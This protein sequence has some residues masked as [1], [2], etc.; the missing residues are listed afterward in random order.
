SD[1]IIMDAAYEY[2]GCA[3]LQ[4]TASALTEMIKGKSID[5]ISSITVEDI[6]NYLEGLP[7][8]KLD[9]AVLASSTLQKALELYKKKEPV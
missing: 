1:D 5:S 4:A 6:I 2:I 9:C 7:K 3:G 8:Q